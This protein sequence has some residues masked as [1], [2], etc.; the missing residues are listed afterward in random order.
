MSQTQTASSPIHAL[1]SHNVARYVPGVGNFIHTRSGG[2]RFV[3]RGRY[4]EPALQ[5]AHSDVRAAAEALQAKV[6]SEPAVVAATSDYNKAVRDFNGLK[7]DPFSA[8]SKIRL[9][10]D[11]ALAKERSDAIADAR[12]VLKEARKDAIQGAAHAEKASYDAARKSRKQI[13]GEILGRQAEWAQLAAE[14]PKTSAKIKPELQKMASKLERKSSA[15]LGTERP[16]SGPLS[17]P[18]LDRAKQAAGRGKIFSGRNAVIAIGAVG[19]GALLYK[20]MSGDKEQELSAMTP[21]LQGNWADRVDA[22]KYM[23]QPSVGAPAR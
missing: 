4:A 16:L 21:A 12:S 6:N 5:S 17:N 9:G 2:M 8:E 15:L 11:P 23:P 14:N 3:N 18:A 7:E 13:H 22:S 19:G 1:K 10:V 20:I